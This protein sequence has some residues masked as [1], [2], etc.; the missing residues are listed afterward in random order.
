[1]RRFLAV[2]AVL[3]LSAPAW[4]EVV[5]PTQQ[6]SHIFVSSY[7]TA[8]GGGGDCATCSDNL[9]QAFILDDGAA[10]L[11]DWVGTNDLSLGAGGAA[12]AWAGSNNGL[13][14]DGT[15]D[16][17]SF[18][19]TT[20]DWQ[21]GYTVAIL[22]T[23]PSA[24]HR[25]LFH[26]SD[27][28]EQQ[29]EFASNEFADYQRA[30]ARFGRDFNS[31]VGYLDACTPADGTKKWYFLEYEPTGTDGTMSLYRDSASSACD[32]DVDVEEY[33]TTAMNSGRLGSATGGSDF[34][35]TTI[36]RVLTYSRVLTSTEKQAIL[37]GWTPTND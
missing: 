35:G 37:D 8:G 27:G 11:E 4:A 21:P 1:M 25:Y 6:R 29:V 10:T 15:D 23:V 14:F 28:G 33:G 5:R 12:P 31:G 16:Y 13:V 19:P 34:A 36:Y 9:T 32:T 2:L 3:L 7:P 26:I 18:T 17:A 20:Q 24:A 30:Q 22:C